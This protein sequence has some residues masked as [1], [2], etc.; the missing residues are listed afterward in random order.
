MTK[1]KKSLIFVELMSYFP[2]LDEVEVHEYSFMDEHILLISTMDPLYG[3]I[4]IY[5]QTL[6]VPPCHRMSV[7]SYII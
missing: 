6:K 1:S 3:D 2:S 7:N 4:M 5:L